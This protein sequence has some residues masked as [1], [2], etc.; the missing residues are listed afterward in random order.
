V[1]LYPSIPQSLLYKWVPISLV[2]DV[3]KTTCIV[4]KPP[5][6]PFFDFYPHFSP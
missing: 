6:S 1:I 2:L 4:K 5:G 3:G